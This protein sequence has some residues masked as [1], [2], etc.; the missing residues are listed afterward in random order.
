MTLSVEENFYTE[1]DVFD[2]SNGF[3]LA[4]GFADH[5]DNPIDPERGELAFYR[6]DWWLNE[7]GGFQ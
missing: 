1:Q 6:H 5:Y 2:S 4:V 3:A 7:D